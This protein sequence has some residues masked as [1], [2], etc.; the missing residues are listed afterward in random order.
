[1]AIHHTR[2]CLLLALSIWVTGSAIAEPTMVWKTEGLK[3]PESVVLDADR[4]VLFVSN[5]GGPPMEKNG[6][7]HI[8]RLS[9]DGAVVDA[10]WVTG[11]NAPTGLIQNGNTLYVPD[12]D[13]LVAINV[14]SGEIVGTWDGE[15][16]TFLNDLA[17]DESGRIYASDMVNNAIYVLDGD[18][19]GVWLQDSALD[20][21]NGLRVE[22]DRLLVA[23]WGA[24]KDDFSTEI[25]GHLKA[26]DLNTKAITS[27]SDGT[28]IGNLDGLEPDGQGG[29][30]V[31]DWVAGGVFRINADGS[32]EQVIDL[33]SGSADIEYVESES[34]L[35]VPMM[36]DGTLAAY[37]L[38]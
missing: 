26:V 25:P 6:A 29:W 17:M 36:K 14:E 27:V 28:P 21:P 11:L 3:N 8:S 9:P 13:R 15:G 38:E 1:M 18:S 37:R 4:S 16:A 19:F 20:N 23:S 12:I 7:G 31:S 34:L 30:L 2:P 32:F 22:G 5:V 24:M 10:E 33:D 35:L